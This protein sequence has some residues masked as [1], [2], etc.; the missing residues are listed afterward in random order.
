MSDVGFT[1]DKSH[2]VVNSTMSVFR[3]AHSLWHL[4][5]MSY[6]G[7]II[8]VIY[9]YERFRTDHSLCTMSY[10]GSIRVKYHYELGGWANSWSL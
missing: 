3:I 7:S 9:H 10:A 2:Q 5:T 4:C 8:R 6:V 1:V